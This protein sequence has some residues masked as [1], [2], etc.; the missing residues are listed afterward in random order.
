MTSSEME[1][2]FAELEAAG[3][4]A[5]NGKMRK[6]KPVYVTAEWCLK[7]N[8]DHPDVFE[9]LFSA[10]GDAAEL[11]RVYARHKDI[12]LRYRQ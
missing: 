4:I 10:C 3:L 8:R 1:A 12:L 9:E 5:K 2:R 6:G 11:Q 7:L